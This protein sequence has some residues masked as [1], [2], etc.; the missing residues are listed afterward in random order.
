MNGWEQVS[1]LLGSGVLAAALFSGAIGTWRRGF[2]TGIICA[3]FAA[4]A[5]A[6]IALPLWLVFAVYDHR[7]T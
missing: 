4:I 1:V 6:M 7:L 5:T 2:A 3:L